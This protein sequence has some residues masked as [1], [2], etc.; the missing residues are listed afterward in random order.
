MQFLHV[1]NLLPLA[2]FGALRAIFPMGLY[3]LVRPAGVRIMVGER[4]GFILSLPAARCGHAECVRGRDSA[5]TRACKASA[6]QR[7]ACG[8][9]KAT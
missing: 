7:V 1:Y 3:D 5:V 4:F 2:L 9:P 8:E 6:E